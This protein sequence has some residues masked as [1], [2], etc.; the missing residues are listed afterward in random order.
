M[1]LSD[2][3]DYVPQCHN[4]CVGSKLFEAAVWVDSMENWFMYVA[5]ILR[6]LMN[7]SLAYFKDFEE[8]LLPKFCQ[9]CMDNIEYCWTV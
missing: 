4:I 9:W 8:D 7:E 2:N 5:G 1:A 6:K 3:K